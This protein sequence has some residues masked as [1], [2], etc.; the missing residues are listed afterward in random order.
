MGVIMN[1]NQKTPSE[2]LATLVVNRMIEAGLLRTEKQASLIEKISAGDMK[3][4]D[5]KLEIEIMNDK[6]A[7]P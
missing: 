6:V 3:G 4:E 7:Q 2:M 1:Q 5:W